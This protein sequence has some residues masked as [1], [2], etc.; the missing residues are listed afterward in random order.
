MAETVKDSPMLFLTLGSPAH[1]SS[2]CS[3]GWVRMKD[4]MRSVGS[5]SAEAI[6]SMICWTRASPVGSVAVVRAV[7]AA[8]GGVFLGKF[9][10]PVEGGLTGVE[11]AGGHPGRPG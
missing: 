11:A 4:A 6:D 3:G 7:S 9:L 8:A 5:S 2:D 1:S 10:T